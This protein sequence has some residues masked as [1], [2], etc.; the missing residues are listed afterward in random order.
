MSFLYSSAISNS[1]GGQFYYGAEAGQNGWKGGDRRQT[2]ADR[3]GDRQ[4]GMEGGGGDRDGLILLFRCTSFLPAA[5]SCLIF[6]AAAF[7]SSA[8][9]VSACLLSPAS[10]HQH[11]RYTCVLQAHH[12]FSTSCICCHA[13]RALA[14]RCMPSPCWHGMAARAI[15]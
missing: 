7:C 11:A 4:C 5:I 6:A 12:S 9:T 13:M 2:E 3:E 1:L 10:A 15:S 8:V 14:V